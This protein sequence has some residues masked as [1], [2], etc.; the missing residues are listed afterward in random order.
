MPLLTVYARFLA[1]LPE[2]DHAERRLR[3]HLDG[4]EGAAQAVMVDAGDGR[5][6]GRSGWDCM[7]GCCAHISM[8]APPA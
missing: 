8:V 1:V 5:G 2:D 3:E 7:D 6:T 4:A